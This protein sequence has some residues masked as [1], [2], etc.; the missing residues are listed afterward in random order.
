MSFRKNAEVDVEMVKQNE[1]RDKIVQTQSVI[2]GIQQQVQEGRQALEKNALVNVELAQQNALR[3][4]LH[5]IGLNQVCY[6]WYLAIVTVIFYSL[7]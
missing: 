7:G 5:Q 6:F 4:K 1:F 3:R 2:S